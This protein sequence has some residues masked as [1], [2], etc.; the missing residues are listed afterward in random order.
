MEGLWFIVAYVLAPLCK[1]WMIW[2]WAT[3]E[4]PEVFKIEE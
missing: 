4:P 1:A 3:R 2:K